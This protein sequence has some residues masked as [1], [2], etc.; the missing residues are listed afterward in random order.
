MQNESL[1]K[2]TFVLTLGRSIGLVINIFLP[3]C[4]VRVISISDF[5][6]YKLIGTI[7]MFVISTFPLGM[8]QSLYYFLPTFCDRRKELLS[9]TM[10]FLLG[11]ATTIIVVGFCLHQLGLL[12]FIK[13]FNNASALIT[14]FI[15]AITILINVTP[16]FL[17]ATNQATSGAKYL[18][19]SDLVGAIT[20]LLFAFWGKNITWVLAGWV[21]GCILLLVISFLYIRS[22]LS[23]HIS[24]DLMKMQVKYSFPFGLSNIVNSTQFYLHQF[25]ISAFFSPTMFAMYAVGTF[26]LPLVR[27]WYSSVADVILVRMTEL[28]AEGNVAEVIKVWLNSIRKLALVFIPAMV[29]MLVVSRPFIT[30]VFTTQY[31]ESVPIF[32]FSLAQY[33]TYVVNCHSVLRAFDETKFILHNNLIMLVITIILLIPL[34]YLLGVIGAVIATVLAA[35][36]SNGL[37]L[38][39]ISI[40]LQVRVTQLFPW[41]DLK[42]ISVLSSG[43]GVVAWGAAYFFSHDIIQLIVA[44]LVFCVVYLFGAWKFQGIM[45]TEERNALHMYLFKVKQRMHLSIL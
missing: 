28:R 23:L 41:S 18:A 16:P 8:V 10:L 2:K 22:H 33:L 21:S 12:W 24:A 31:T 35:Y 36:I 7:V 42:Q 27:I 19:V 13:G 40:I 26:Q 20:I 32:I 15:L 29:L 30:T 39:R 34:V 6:I 11:I 4:L 17:I 14:L 5:G 44:G 38:R 3:I 1:T 43:A 9:N 45:S 25:V 37:M